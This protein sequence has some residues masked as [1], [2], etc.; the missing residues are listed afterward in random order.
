M[1]PLDKARILPPYTHTYTWSLRFKD[2]QLFLCHAKVQDLLFS[3]RHRTV[4]KTAS[5][6][7][8]S[9][10][11][12]IPCDQGS[13]QHIMGDVVNDPNSLPV[14]QMTLGPPSQDPTGESSKAPTQDDDVTR[15]EPVT[16]PNVRVS[17][18]GDI[19]ASKSKSRAASLMLDKT[20]VTW[21]TQP[22]GTYF[23]VDVMP[24]P[25]SGAKM[26]YD[27]SDGTLTP[28][29]GSWRSLFGKSVRR[30]EVQYHPDSERYTGSRRLDEPSKAADGNL[31]AFG[32]MTVTL[33]NGSACTKL[34]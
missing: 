7:V 12:H 5:K 9:L 33:A 2:R 20:S 14:S 8:V 16:I 28:Y 11:T 31:E 6:M 21:Q 24:A 22:I 34:G 13:I 26:V 25:L 32:T 17:V 1:K 15:Q 19:R 4:I 30:Y 18:V 10:R 29:E 27:R 23:P 3:W